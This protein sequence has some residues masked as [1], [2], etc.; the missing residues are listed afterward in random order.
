M[1]KEFTA[2]ILEKKRKIVIKKIKVP[3]LEK[4]QVLVKII[5][6]GICGSQYF[7]YFGYRGKDIYLPHGLGHE[8]S[9]IIVEKHRSLKK[10][11]KG[12][13]VIL[14][15][16]K[17]KD[18]GSKKIILNDSDKRSINFGP[19]TTFS[20]YSLVSSNRVFLKPPAMSMIEAVF[21]GCAIPTGAGMVLNQSKVKVNDNILLIGIGGI[22]YVVLRTLLKLKV[23]KITIVEND[24]TKI[25]YIKKI[26]FNK[27]YNLIYLNNI[28]KVKKN[29]F[30]I[31]F[32]TSG[33][34]KI[35]EKSLSFIND[36]GKVLFASHPKFGEKISLNPHELI[37]GKQI[38]G[39]WG[40]NSKLNKDITKIFKFFDNKSIFNK[41]LLN[42]V[43]LKDLKFIFEKNNSKIRNVISFGKK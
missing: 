11:K 2:A 28:S 5:Y 16:L 22:G 38:F 35:L 9:G 37:K 41:N 26:L 27:N 31:C 4:N 29:E 13:R 42:I 19:I 30:D 25:N 10:F 14:S 32:E 8:A 12:D 20:N 3:K 40:G 23:K 36:K 39:S 21:Y 15:W 17:N 1:K 33:N 34:I 6:S 24:K 18:Q 43:K 7:E